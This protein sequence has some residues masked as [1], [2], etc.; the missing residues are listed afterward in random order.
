MHV[1]SD[2]S[3]WCGYSLMSFPDRQQGLRGEGQVGRAGDR[4]RQIG[5][6]AM[7]DTLLLV[8]DNLASPVYFQLGALADG[9]AA[10]LPQWQPSAHSWTRRKDR[11]R[12]A[13]STLVT[14][15]PFIPRALTETR[16]SWVSGHVRCDTAKQPVSLIFDTRSKVEG[17]GTPARTA[18]SRA[19]R[20][21][22]A[23]H[24]R[25]AVRPL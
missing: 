2:A 9:I 21:Q 3:M 1:F 18:I 8:A 17:T 16:S 13:R 20:P 25:L 11:Y 15:S 12:H 19:D 14:K 10:R 6:T 23:D 5:W 4:G 7:A 24:D 22:I